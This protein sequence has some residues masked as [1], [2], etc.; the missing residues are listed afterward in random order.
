MAA[1]STHRLP[2]LVLVDHV[3]DLPLDHASVEGG[4]VGGERIEVYGREVRAAGAD[5]EAK[6][7]LVF[8]AGGPGFESPRPETRS[9]WLARACRD[10]RVLLLDQRGTGRSSPLEA[11]ALAALGDDGLIAERLSHFRADSIVRDCEAIRRE[12]VGDD[13]RW[14]VLGQS[15]GGFC[16]VHYLST[17]PEGLREVLI[18]GGLPPLVDEPLPVYRRT[19]ATL[20]AK[21]AAYHARYPEDAE[22]LRAIAD[23]SAPGATRLPGGDRLTAGRLQSLG[24]QLGFRD[25]PARVHYLLERAW[26]G[27]GAGR[28]LSF[29]F[30]RGLEAIQSFDSNPLY[31][32][33][34]EACYAQGA[35]T[36]WAAQQVVEAAADLAPTVDPFPFTGEMV[37]RWTFEDSAVLRPLLGAADRLAARE[38]WPRLYDPERLAANAV[39]VAAAVWAHDMFVDRELS[40]ETAGQIAGCRTWLTD[41]F[42]HCG[43]R[44]GGERVL[45]RLLDLVRGEA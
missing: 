2:G 13:G 27:A 32:L 14:S 1:R 10:Y 5:A 42:E 25:G 15:F 17:A 16:A 18:T 39:P 11:R 33:I 37:F 28:D 38:D 12:L 20:R 45:G 43:L 40:L 41:E 26:A 6:P 4:A 44:V 8:L 3:F 22:R 9:G 35:A 24:L 23:R 34:H 31:A 36:G 30:L 21:T 7:W 19:L 29:A